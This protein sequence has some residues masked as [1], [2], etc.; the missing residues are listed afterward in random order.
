MLQKILAW[1]KRWAERLVILAGALFFA[2]GPQFVNQ[3]EDHLEGHVA[4]LHYQVALVGEIATIFHM[5]TPQYIQKLSTK[6][7]PETR[8]QAQFLTALITR[9][10]KLDQH[11]TSLKNAGPWGR[12][13]AFLMYFDR[14]LAVETFHSFK[15]GLVLTWNTFFWALFG[16]FA[17]WGGIRSLGA[18]SQWIKRRLRAV[19]GN[20][21]IGTAGPVVKTKFK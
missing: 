9:T 17:A 11:L 18:I 6:D 2:Q 3:Y 13:F 16:G 19:F 14:T 5:D 1:F 4:E 21:P 7:D 10:S 8:E 12:S 20:P 15:S